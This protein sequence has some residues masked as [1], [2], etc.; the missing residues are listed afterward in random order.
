MKITTKFALITALTLV[1]VLAVAGIAMAATVSTYDTATGLYKYDFAPEETVLIKGDGFTS[2]TAVDVKVTRP[3]GSIVKGDGTFTPGFDTVLISAEGNLE[4]LYILD[5]IQGTYL[6]NCYEAG[7]SNLI[8][9][10]DFTDSRFKL[11]GWDKQQL[12]WTP[13]NIGG[14]NEG[15]LVDFSLKITVTNKDIQDGN[16]SFTT[17]FGVWHNR[18]NGTAPGFDSAQDFAVAGG[19]WTPINSENVGDNIQYNG[20][21]TAPAVGV[22]Y[23]TWKG[24]L[25]I[26]SSAWP[27]GNIHTG[28][29]PIG[30]RTVPCEI[31]GIGQPPV[32]T[33]A[34][35]G[36]VSINGGAAS[37]DTTAVTLGLSAT[38]N[39][40][41]T[42]MMVSN[43]ADFSGAS[44]VAYA[45]SMAW[46]LTGGDGTKTVY[47]KYKD[48]AGN[49]SDDCNDS[50]VLDTVV[51][52]TEDPI[53]TVSIN[54]GAAYTKTA[55]VTLS[56]SATDNVGVTSMIVS[57]NV[58]FVGADWEMYSAS[59]KTWTLTA[60]NGTN[61]VYVKY[62]DLAG[63]ESDPVSTDS[64]VLDTVGPT[65]TDTTG[66]I[67]RPLVTD[68]VITAN[69]TDSVSG[70]GSVTLHYQQP[71]SGGFIKDVTMTNIGGNTYQ[72]TIPAADFNAALEYDI[73]AYDV[74]GNMALDG[75][76]D[77]VPLVVALPDVT[78]LSPAS[79]PEGTEVT[80]TGTD[81]GVQGSSSAVSF[82]GT[83]AVITSWT[84]TSIVVT[85]PTGATDGEVVVTNDVGSSGPGDPDSFFDVTV[86]PSLPPAVTSVT[87]SSGTTAGGI[88]ITI[89]GSNFVSG[90]S[91]TL[92]GVA[93][94]G[95]VVVDPQ[96]IYATTGP[97]ASGIVDVVVTN[98]DAQIG[99]LEGG[100]AY[101]DMARTEE[102][103]ISY[104]H[105]T[106]STAWG[107]FSPS[108][109]GPSSGTQSYSRFADAWA[110]FGFRG[111]GIDWLISTQENYAI[112]KVYID[113]VFKQNVDLYSSI[114]RD[115]QVVY[116]IRGLDPNIGH[117]IRIVH[118]GTKNPS[119]TDTYIGVDAFD[120]V[121]GGSVTRVQEQNFTLT[122]TWGS[123]QAAG[124]SA[125]TQNY[126]KTAGSTATYV[127]VGTG[128]DWII[129][130]Q[131]NYGKAKVTIDGGAYQIVDLYRPV[132]TL[133]D[134]PYSKR[135]LLYGTHT[136]K[137]ECTGTKNAA[138][139][140]YYIGIDAL[141]IWY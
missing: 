114:R 134:M 15:D 76:F 7:T 14:Y 109:G 60:G 125:G 99:T 53:G 87:P 57:D 81:F 37:T 9:S 120:V 106:K 119:A 73:I 79:G 21:F 95:V 12:N 23:L 131:N 24:H 139:Y 64:I 82:N 42:M 104:G 40:G 90:A 101:A 52:D 117:T 30:V 74:A 121:S 130:T 86:P 8:V 88:S 33:Q 94:T 34:P 58:A 6:I 5:G 112:A 69:V 19:T 129:A 4:Y 11:E 70:V 31:P 61:T 85:V 91:V 18:I 39:V 1:M 96:T 107:Y 122:G 13:G 56:L 44:W 28:A 100:Y 108:G 133:Q 78:N 116:S 128:V 138:S 48:A 47:V 68:V 136:I 38:D 17:T 141:N 50:I 25:A 49:I 66:D 72:G 16:G 67:S 77:I 118:S 123:Y 135:D 65:I 22:Y 54:S 93:A 127:F 27:S 137:I 3:D 124:T 26:G 126:T 29:T 80:I 51:P 20:T 75:Y 132:A 55:V 59:P 105:P 71:G 103:A 32:D 41:V 111:T 115:Q 35:V 84:D 89:N 98:P 45:T 92:G 2:L 140:D 83:P 113:G 10:G 110:E 97:H 36:S 43:N 102:T 62:K 63:N 46:T